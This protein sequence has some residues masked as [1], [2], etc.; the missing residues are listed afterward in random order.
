MDREMELRRDLAMPG[1]QPNPMGG[2]TF[3]I[4]YRGPLKTVWG[5]TVQVVQTVR[6]VPFGRDAW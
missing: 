5:A 2:E 1:Q 6:N 4:T 3:T